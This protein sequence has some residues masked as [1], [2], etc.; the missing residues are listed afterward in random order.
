DYSTGVNKLKF[1]IRKDALNDAI[2]VVSKAV[3]PR[4]TIPIL[5]GIKLDAT[6]SGITLTGSDTDISIQ[7][8][9]PLENDDETI[10]TIH[11]PGSVVL[12]A[13]FFVDIVRKLPTDS[14]E[15]ELG[16]NFQTQI[17]SGSSEIQLVG[18]DPE[19]FPLLPVLE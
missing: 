17:R 16:D 7:C 12:P 3:S 18:L 1:T 4:T 9:I 2:Q 15:L 11:S 5:S 13:I 6:P 8:F 19:E 14:V 10:A